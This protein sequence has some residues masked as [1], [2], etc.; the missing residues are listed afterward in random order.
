MY[1]TVLSY[2]QAP[3]KN[4][5]TVVVEQKSQ[6]GQNW[7]ENLEMLAWKKKQLRSNLE[8]KCRTGNVG[9]IRPEKNPNINFFMKVKSHWKKLHIFS[10]INCY[11]G[12]RQLPSIWSGRTSSQTKPQK[13]ADCCS[14]KK[15]KASERSFFNLIKQEKVRI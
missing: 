7:R 12:D 4:S 5:L 10:K 3:Q 15:N 2:S 14:P 8:F 11:L 1:I 13:S 9:E 6:N